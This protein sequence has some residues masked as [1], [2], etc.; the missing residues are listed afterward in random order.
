MHTFQVYFEASGNSSNV[1]NYYLIY[2]R[3]NERV[4]PLVGIAFEKTDIHFGD[5][6]KFN[7][8]VYTAG[9]DATDRVRIEIYTIEDGSRVLIDGDRD[10]TLVNVPNSHID[11]Y[12]IL[13]YPQKSETYKLYVDFIADKIIPAEEEGED[14]TI[15]STTETISIDIR[16]FQSSYKLEYA[17]TDAL[18]YSYTAYGRTNNDA[19]KETHHYIFNTHEVEH[20]TIDFETQFNNFNWSTNGYVDGALTVSGGATCDINVPVFSAKYDEISI[21]G[22]DN[23][24]DITERG[25]TVEIDYEVVSAINLNDTIISCMNPNSNAGFKITPQNC[26]LT[27]NNRPANIS[28]DGTGNILNESSI[29]AAYLTTGQRTHLVFVIEPWATT[30]AYDKKYH[31]SVNIY[32]NGEFAN[33]SPYFRDNSSGA[34]V[35]NFSTDAT[36]HIG[37]SSCII[38]LYGIKLYNRGLSPNEVLQNYKMAPR[39]TTEKIARFDKNNVLKNNKVD[40]ELARKKFNCL[41]LVGPE[42]DYALN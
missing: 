23:T 37:N 27:S 11:P 7:Y 39:L 9:Q 29:A 8:T 21:E 25:R 10:N 12:T 24:R 31:Q 42:P 20:P 34:I 28:A 19:D 33:A 26:Y 5:E 6:L 17:G 35:D 36:I 40:Y 14:P 18:L 13:E 22:S 2:N 3:D 4:A 32:I 38:K 15:I 1:L 30:Q 41:L 16:P